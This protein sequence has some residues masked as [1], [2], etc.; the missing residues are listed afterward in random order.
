MTAPTQLPGQRPL[1]QPL[2]PLHRTLADN[3]RITQHINAR[4]AGLAIPRPAAAMPRPRHRHFTHRGGNHI[5]A[6]RA[7]REH[8]RPPGHRPACPATRVLAGHLQDQQ[9]DGQARERGDR[10]GSSG[11]PVS[12]SASITG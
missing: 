8:K 11:Q 7:G 9:A 12:R 6:G 3:R 5:R 1:A 2:T 10:A 4:T